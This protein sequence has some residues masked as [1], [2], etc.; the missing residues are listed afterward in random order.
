MSVS[1]S[2][3][4]VFDSLPCFQSRTLCSPTCSE[5]PKEISHLISCLRGSASFLA[6]AKW[7]NHSIICLEE[8]SFTKDIKNIFGKPDHGHNTARR[9]FFSQL[10]YT[11]YLFF[12]F[13]LESGYNEEALERA[14]MLTIKD[15]FHFSCH[16]NPETMQPGQARI[17]T[18]SCLCSCS[19]WPAKRYVQG[20]KVAL[21]HIS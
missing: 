21:S 6:T 15:N 16:P 7:E 2:M 19:Q 20:T 9:L 3:Q 1:T 10:R 5:T 18:K 8:S 17:N 4:L 13:T 14:L 12:S 11:L